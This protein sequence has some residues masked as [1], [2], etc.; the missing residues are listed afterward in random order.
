MDIWE[1]GLDIE[2][3]L[4]ENELLYLANK[5]NVPVGF[6]REIMNEVGN[7]RQEIENRLAET[8]KQISTG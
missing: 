3:L 2:G 8:G 7:N 4:I 1:I 5:Y 6:V